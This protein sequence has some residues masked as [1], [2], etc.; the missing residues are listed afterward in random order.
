MRKSLFRRVYICGEL[1]MTMCS[2]TS[3]KVKSNKEKTL[4]CRK[5]PPPPPPLTWCCWTN[6]NSSQHTAHIEPYRGLPQILRIRENKQL[7]TLVH[8][9]VRCS[10]Y[11]SQRQAEETFTWRVFAQKPKQGS[12]YIIRSRSLSSAVCNTDICVCA[13]ITLALCV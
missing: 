2:P 4:N 12:M 7:L 3:I 10:S 8:H 5:K 13:A 1:D 9:G 6:V 11:D